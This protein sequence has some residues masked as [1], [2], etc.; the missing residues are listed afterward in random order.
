[1]GMKDIKEIFS[2][3]SEYHD[4]PIRGSKFWESNVYYRVEDL[5]NDEIEI[6]AAYLAERIINVC[7]PN[8]PKIIINIKGS[9][10]GLSSVIA[11]K[12]RQLEDIDPEVVKY[13]QIINGAYNGKS[14]KNMEAI[15]V[16]DVITTAKS[17]LEAHSKVTMM[18]AYIYCWVALIDR[19]FGPGPVPIVA[20]FTGE[21][22][23]LTD[24]RFL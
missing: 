23:T 16:N 18:G 13:E 15:L 8:L 1:M 12:L 10:L 5:S 17:C 6:C 19:T 22:V 4:T 7:S 11:E 14:L 21:P 20:A 9:Y 24:T 3:I 2:R